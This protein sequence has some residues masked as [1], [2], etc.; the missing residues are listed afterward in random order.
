MDMIGYMYGTCERSIIKFLTLL[1]V[2][3]IDHGNIF[4]ILRLIFIKMPEQTFSCTIIMCA[5]HDID[6]LI[7]KVHCELSPLE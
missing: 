3:G 5:N 4:S 6:N 1:I 7:E 2:E